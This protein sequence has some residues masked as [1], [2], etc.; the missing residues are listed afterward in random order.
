MFFL[1]A[2]AKK[3]REEEEFVYLKAL[4]DEEASL[5]SFLPV[6]GVP[7]RLLAALSSLPRTKLPPGPPGPPG[8]RFRRPLLL[9]EPSM[10]DGPNDGGW[11]VVRAVRRRRRSS[12]PTLLD[13]K[14]GGGVGW[15]NPEKLRASPRPI[16]GRPPPPGPR[17][18]CCRIR[19]I[20]A[21][22]AARAACRN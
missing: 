12:L 20:S 9:R 14:S 19:S 21:F 2:G 8:P 4:I 11:L 18:A 1:S 10:L 7:V 13:A 16:G 3:P 17:L 15:P 22:C 6:G 5:S